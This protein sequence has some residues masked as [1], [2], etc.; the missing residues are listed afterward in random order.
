MGQSLGST[1]W[2][3]CKDG[4]VMMIPRKGSPTTYT[5]VSPVTLGFRALLKVEEPVDQR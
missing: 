5:G 2:S 4:H 3:C 1:R